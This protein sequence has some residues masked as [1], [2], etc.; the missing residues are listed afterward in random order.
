[1]RDLRLAARSLRASPVVSIVA[2]LSLALGIG[3][4]TAMFSLVDSLLLRALP[5]KQQHQL[6][7]VSV[8]VGAGASV[9]ASKFVATLLYG[10]EPRDPATLVGSAAVLARRR[11]RRL[12][13][14]R[15]RVPHRSR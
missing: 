12:D 8:L 13:S 14:R 9:W 11:P 6:A 5:V 2:A 7:L 15:P 4:N 1:V 3:A 10:L